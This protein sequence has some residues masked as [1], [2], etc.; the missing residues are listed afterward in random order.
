MAT[1]VALVT[2]AN[3][4]IGFALVRRLAGEAVKLGE[5]TTVV[6]GCRSKARGDEAVKKIVEEFPGAS[7]ELLVID[8]SD[9]ASVL[10]ASAE[11][12]RRFGR[13]DALY[14][15]AGI[16]P[17][18]GILLWPFDRTP[19]GFVK[20]PRGLKTERGFGQVFATNLLGHHMLIEEL[21]DALAAARPGRV[22][23]VSSRTS[24]RRHFSWED[25]QHLSGPDAYGTSK[26]LCDTVS[27]A[28]NERLRA[29]DVYVFTACP[30]FVFSGLTEHMIY[31]RSLL[32]WGTWLLSWV[33]SLLR[34]SPHA[35][36]EVLHWFW[37]QDPRT[38][39][40]GAKY[41]ANKDDSIGT[42][43]YPPSTLEEARRLEC[44]LRALARPFR[45]PAPAP[46]GPAPR[47]KS[48]SR[49]RTPPRK[50]A[51]QKVS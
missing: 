22:V 23:W 30:G 48:P 32:F 35:G 33:F 36:A 51:A 31:F 2:G 28:L 15:N 46:A 4:G 47:Q 13:L 38:L 12:K 42:C 50:A 16:Y 20:Q 21:E 39:D 3:A 25:L 5:K 7:V 45:A 9:P 11:F 26:F 49:A 29:R 6:L 17:S 27:K 41:A 18:S 40:T 1:K 34:V 10:E 44:E 24:S 8:V 43:W 19:W 37:R 14:L